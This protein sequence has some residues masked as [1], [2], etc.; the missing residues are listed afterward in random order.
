MTDT[1]DSATKRL[2][3]C[4][5]GDQRLVD[6]ARAAGLAEDAAQ[7]I[8]GIDGVM[9]RIR[10]SMLRR[11]FGR[12]LLARLDVDLEI[13]HLDTIMTIGVNVDGEGGGDE[14]TVGLVAERLGIDPSR[15]SRLVSEMVERG[16]VLRVAS[17]A[18][19]RRICLALTGKGQTFVN[20][21]RENKWRLFSASLGQWPADELVTFAR[22]LERFSTWATDQ[23][24]IKNSA[25][26]IL[27]ALEAAETAS[28][29]PPARML[30]DAG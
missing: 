30:A 27:A 16:Y 7:A 2:D 12:A 19:A 25:D 24:G 15:A 17:Q 13:P 4:P 23:E 18:D 14:V 8:A 5:P 28:T 1:P 29:T 3:R 11:D 6:M 26:T 22:L 10:R 9:H 21:V 20:A